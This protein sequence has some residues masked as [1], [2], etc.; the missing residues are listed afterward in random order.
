[1]PNLYRVLFVAQSFSDTPE[2]HHEFLTDHGC[3]VIM[4]ARTH[5]L[6]SS[7][8]AELI[9]GFDGAILGLDSCDAS[10]IEKTDQLR[11]I[12]RYGAGVSEIDPEASA[13]YA[14]LQSI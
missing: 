9:P 7:E 4:A 8:L 1:M 12:S 11:V 14:K 10:V 13:R 5:P 3:E 6:T 2:V